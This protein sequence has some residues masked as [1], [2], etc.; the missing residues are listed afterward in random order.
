VLADIRHGKG[1]FL[2]FD[3]TPEEWE[4]YTQDLP[5]ADKNRKVRFTKRHIYISDGTEEILYEIFGLNSN[6]TRLREISLDNEFIVFTVRN[7]ELI[8]DE[9]GEEK[10]DSPDNLKQYQILIPKAQQN[11]ADEL[12]NFYQRLIDKNK[13]DRNELPRQ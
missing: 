3:Y 12:I 5:L 2:T 7:Q 10:P 9:D 4:Y 13:R 11:Q 6:S 1:I 8:T